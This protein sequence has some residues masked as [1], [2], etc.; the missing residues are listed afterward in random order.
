MADAGNQEFPTVLG[1]D[2][3]FKGEMSFEKG[4]RVMGHFEGKVNTPGRLHVAKEAKM[5][6]DV[7]A[8]GIIV[9]SEVQG[10]LSA[11]DPIQL[12]NSAPQERGPRAH[13][14]VGDEGGG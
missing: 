3:R 10:K 7:E 8:G 2:A 13:K 12:K 4:M 6:A 14:I 1:P 5:Q 9:E 11:T